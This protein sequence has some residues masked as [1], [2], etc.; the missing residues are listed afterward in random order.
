MNKFN[1]EYRRF[2]EWMV[3]YFQEHEEY[4]PLLLQLDLNRWDKIK[5]IGDLFNIWRS[6]P[7]KVDWFIC[8]QMLK[9]GI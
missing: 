7:D 2:T 4:Q 5:T 3:E 6:D 1:D 9:R 8:N